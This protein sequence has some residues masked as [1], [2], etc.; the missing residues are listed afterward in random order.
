M[1]EHPEY[2]KQH[3]KYMREA[4]KEAKKAKQED[5]VPVGAIIVYQN[6]IIARAYNQVERLKDPSAHAEML[7]ITS[8]SAALSQKYLKNCTLYVTLEPCV[9]C[10]GALVWSKIETVIFGASDVNSGACGTVFNLSNSDKLNHHIEI[11]QGILE[12]ECE[13][14]LKTFFKEKRVSSLLNNQNYKNN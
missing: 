2:L 11:I 7:A 8:A 13:D 3:Q 1:N 14:L 12:Y 4:L 10:S 6:R 5:E 9:M